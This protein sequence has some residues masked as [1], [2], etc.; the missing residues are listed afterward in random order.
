[1]SP[2]KLLFL[3]AAAFNCKIM[4]FLLIGFHSVG[5]ASKL[6]FLLFFFFTRWC[7]FFQVW[8]IKQILALFLASKWGKFGTASKQ[9]FTES[10]FFEI[11]T[12]NLEHKLFRFMVLIF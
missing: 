12:S 10:S 9:N 8:S 7:H 2:L 1:M 11:S 4:Q 5:K 3:I 6:N